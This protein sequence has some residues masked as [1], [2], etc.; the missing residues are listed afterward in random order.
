MDIL[1]SKTRNELL[2]S[3]VAELAKAGNELKCAQTDITKAQSR[4]N[5]L[6]VVANE[7]INRKD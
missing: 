5:F 6:L 3:L 7:L 1:D 2:K 4:L